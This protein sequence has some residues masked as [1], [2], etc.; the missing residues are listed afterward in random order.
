ML[1][2]DEVARVADRIGK[3]IETDR[4]RPWC[5]HRL[6]EEVLRPWKDGGSRADLLPLARAAADELVRRGS[7]RSEPVSAIAIG[8]H[9]D[10]LLIWSQRASAVRLADFGPEY[11]VPLVLR[12]LVSHFECHGL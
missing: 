8:A 2:P 1:V 9:C 11:E 5:V 4:A 12:R 10:D 7:V 6:Y 3:A